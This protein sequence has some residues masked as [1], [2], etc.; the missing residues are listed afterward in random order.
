MHKIFSFLKH[1]GITVNDDEVNFSG[2]NLKITGSPT[3][4]K[5]NLEISSPLGGYAKLLNQSPGAYDYFTFL[6]KDVASQ[7]MGDCRISMNPEEGINLDCGGEVIV[8]L[9]PASIQLGDIN[10]RNNHTYLLIDDNTNRIS[11]KNSGFIVANLTTAE[12]DTISGANGMVIYNID[13]NQFNFY[14]NGSWV[15]K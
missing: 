7:Y 11:I 9:Q 3:A 14:E 10:N 15:T 1:F 13:T 12:R 2:K 8:S 4:D 5:F 6:S